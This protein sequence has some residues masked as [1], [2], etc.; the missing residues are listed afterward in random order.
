MDV[1]EQ[2]WGVERGSFWVPVN[3]KGRGLAR[4]ESTET[5]GVM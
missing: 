4:A 3:M 5:A 1:H 2:G